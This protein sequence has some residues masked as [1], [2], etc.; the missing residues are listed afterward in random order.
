MAAAKQGA[1]T[2]IQDSMGSY[3]CTADIS[4]AGSDDSNGSI[5][6]IE[7]LLASTARVWFPQSAALVEQVMREVN[8]LRS[9]VIES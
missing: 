2:H 5:C 8:A 9:P 1:A 6:D 4:R 3:R 7:P